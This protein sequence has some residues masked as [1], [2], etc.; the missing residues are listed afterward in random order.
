MLDWQGEQGRKGQQ[1]IRQLWT[2][3]TWTSPLQQQNLSYSN[4]LELTIG[5]SLD[6]SEKLVLL[7]HDLFSLM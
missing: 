4:Y 1:V 5:W 3:S 2:L 7:T 6:F